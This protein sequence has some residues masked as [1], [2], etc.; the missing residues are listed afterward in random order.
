MKNGQATIKDIARELKISFSTVSRALKDYPGISEET[1][2]K[3][4]EMAIKLNYRPNAIALSLRKN[5][6]F[7]IA[8]IV[9]EVVHFFFSTVI[10]GIEEIAKKRG[11]NVILTQTNEKLDKEK[12]S[13]EA[14]LSNQIDGFLISYSKETTEFSHFENIIDQGYPIIFFDRIPDIPNSINVKVD[15]FEGAYNAVSHLIS[16]GYENIAHLTGPKNLKISQERER[17]YREALA[18]HGMPIREEMILEC[19]M[20]TN[21]EGKRLA[22]SMLDQL[23]PR[24]DAFFA[25]NDMAA[26][27]VMMACRDSGY[28]IPEEIG[29]VGFSNWQF[30][31]MLEPGLTSVSQPGI[32]MGKKA[33]ELLLDIIEKKVELDTIPN[34]T[35]LNTELFIRK[36]SM[37]L[38]KRS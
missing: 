35:I 21:E 3:V 26:V 38:H 20:G 28:R 5:R 1:K 15:D 2:R 23:N 14:M 13:I 18:N 19:P 22:L 37:R 36:S 12:S 6:S 31:T 33:T 17:G 32:Q 8:V 16:Q 30:C 7:N 11:Y 9:P 34:S 10:S 29:I 24:P 25:N 27:G 4:K